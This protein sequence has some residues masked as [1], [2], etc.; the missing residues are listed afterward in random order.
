[1]EVVQQSV[2]QSVNDSLELKSFEPVNEYLLCKNVPLPTHTS[3]GIEIPE[4]HR[5]KWGGKGEIVLVSADLNPA[6]NK[7]KSGQQIIYSSGIRVM[8]IW[9]DGEK[10]FLLHKSQVGAIVKK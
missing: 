8:E 1:M 3:G 9:I 7:F 5:S 4:E 10:M 2:P 6:M